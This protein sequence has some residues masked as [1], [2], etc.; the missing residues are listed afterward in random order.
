M[1]LT[2]VQVVLNADISKKV[3]SSF[4]NHYVLKQSGHL[5]ILLESPQYSVDD[6]ASSCRELVLEFLVSLCT[7]FQ[8]GICYK[9]KPPPAGLER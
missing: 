1:Y 8:T 4:F 7:N 5:L 6:E 3:K 9:S 2:L